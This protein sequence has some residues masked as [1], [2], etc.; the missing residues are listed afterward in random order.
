MS[1]VFPTR[2]QIFFV[3]ENFRICILNQISLQ[4]VSKGLT[5]RLLEDWL[6]TLGIQVEVGLC[7]KNDEEIHTS[8]KQENWIDISENR[9]I[10]LKMV[11]VLD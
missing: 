7:C 10:F 4:F 1:P 6:W 5:N 2:F 11:N 3:E 8:R 9:E